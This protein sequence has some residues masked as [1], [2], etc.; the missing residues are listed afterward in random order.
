M[1]LNNIFDSLGGDKRI[2]RRVNSLF[3]KM[4][5]KQSAVINKCF[6]DKAPK[7]GAYRVLRNKN[8]DMEDLI[9]RIRQLSG[10]ECVGHKHVLC[11]QDTTELSYDHMKGRLKED[12]PDFGDGSMQLKK[13]S[14]FVHPT[15]IVDAESCLPIGFSSVRIWNRERIEGRKKTNKRA[16]LPYKDKESYRWTL[17]A[18]ESAEC[19]PSDVRKTIVGDRESDV[20]AFMDETLE[21]G[22]DFLIRSTHNR[23]S[24]VGAD[25]DTLTEHLAKQKPMGEYSFSLP[26]RQG[27]KNRTAI[28]EVRFMPITLHAPHS[29][30]GSKEKLDI[31][32]VHV[33]ERADSVPAG[34]EPVE[35]RLL[36]SH[37]VTSLAQAVQCIDWYRCRWLI[38]ELFRLMKSKGFGIEDIQLEDGES[39][40]KMISLTISAVLKCLILKRSY[41]TRREEVSA[42]ILFTNVQLV[43]LH[44]LMGMIHAKNPRSKD[45]RNPFKEDSLL[46]AA[47]IIARLQGWCDMGKDTRPGY[48]TLK[49]GLRV[50]EYQVAFYTNLNKDV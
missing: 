49:E 23:K 47:W 31:Y 2:E 50:F 28:M 12:D 5:E 18:K 48:I 15:M 38:E 29:N 25:L 16:T 44:A 13:Y 21:V 34:E 27:R 17:S 37:E 24:S 40:K 9:D 3:D 46:W 43:V 42:R 30:A 11:I 4:V 45:G 20:Y 19:I 6:E 36:T 22:C 32:C 14:I 26:G 39:T 41:D 35:W 10:S 33:K 7:V 1:Q 8:W